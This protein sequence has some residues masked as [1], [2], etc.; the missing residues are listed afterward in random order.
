MMKIDEKLPY[1]RVFKHSK[2]EKLHTCQKSSINGKNVKKFQKIAKILLVKTGVR[3]VVGRF[4]RNLEPK[5]DYQWS[6]RTKLSN[7][8]KMSKK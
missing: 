4:L 6:K 1:S 5:N 3:L 7:K 2:N 8:L